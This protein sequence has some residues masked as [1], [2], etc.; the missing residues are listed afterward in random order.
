MFTRYLFS[1]KAGLAAESVLKGLAQA[2]M[3]TA[4]TCVVVTTD[5]NDV[6]AVL[7]KLET[8]ERI[9]PWYGGNAAEPAKPDPAPVMVTKTEKRKYNLPILPDVRCPICN[10][11]VSP[12]F[13]LKDGSKCKICSTKAKKLTK[14][15]AAD[16]AAAEQHPDTWTKDKPPTNLMESQVEQQIRPREKFDLSKLT[17]KKVG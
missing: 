6:A 5:D 4:T 17:G 13:M 10:N 7:H 9:K 12:R 16:Q 15:Q 3:I 11:W 2:G 14:A 1:T 8:A